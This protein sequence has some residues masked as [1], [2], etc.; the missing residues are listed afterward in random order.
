MLAVSEIPL[1]EPVAVM[2]T[3]VPPDSATPVTVPSDATLATLEFEELQRMVSAER[4]ELPERDT[5]V[6]CVTTAVAGVTATLTTLMLAVAVKPLGDAV[7]V[8][9]TGDEA[10]ATPVTVPLDATLATEALEELQLIVSPEMEEEADSDTVSP[11][12]M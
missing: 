11:T 1:T 3:G 9:M 2:V 5:V 10:V 8:I 4:V 7:A 6:P 12:E